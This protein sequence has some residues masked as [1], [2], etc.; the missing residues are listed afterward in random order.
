MA[1]MKPDEDLTA[2]L[3]PGCICKG[4]RLH[5]IIEAIDQGAAS[6]GEIAGKT[7][8]GGGGCKGRRCGEKVKELLRRKEN[9]DQQQPQAGITRLVT[10]GYRVNTYIVSCPE[11][12]QGIIIDP[13]GEAEKIL[14]AIAA[15]GVRIRYIFNTHGHADH[16]VANTELRQA[17]D[18]PVCVHEADADFFTRPEVRAA[19]K[20]ELGLEAPAGVDVRLKDGD[21]IPV[22]RLAV[23]VLHTPGHTPGSCCFLVGGDLFTGDTLFV[24]DV[25]RTDL[26]GGSLE[27]LLRSV[28][29][30]ILPLPPET[31]IRPGHD[32]GE[33]PTSTLAWEM[34]ENPYITDFILA[35]E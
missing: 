6:F 11:T 12:K 28:K 3:R 33:T 8:I 29:E 26:T 22:G 15:L 23:R 24:G 13:G 17:L 27:L 20:R 19:A 34:K 30:K 16:I 31:T 25:G 1:P 14:A 21:S 18:A 4:I 9:M 35:A 7:G 32:Y 10:G 5:R 2:R